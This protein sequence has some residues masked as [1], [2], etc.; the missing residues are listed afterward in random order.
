MRQ[1]RCVEPLEGM[2]AQTDDFTLLDYARRFVREVLNG[3]QCHSRTR[4]RNSVRRYSEKV[5]QRAAFVSFNLRK[6]NVAE[7]L[8]N[9]PIGAPS[10]GI[11]K[12][13]LSN[14]AQSD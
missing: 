6:R 5:V 8:I 13:V 7:I 9:I 12:L 11:L 1:M 4:K 14:A 2:L 10:T 3:Y